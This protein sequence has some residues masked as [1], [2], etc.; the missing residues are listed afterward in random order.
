LPI[1]FN[2]ITAIFLNGMKT[3]VG[4]KNVIFDPTYKFQGGISFPQRP[5]RHQGGQEGHR[6]P[7]GISKF[8]LMTPRLLSQIWTNS[9]KLTDPSPGLYMLGRELSEEDA[10]F[11]PVV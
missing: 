4:S 7:G 5:G 6:G 8:L 3:M 2:K 11:D 1:E 9:C 10:D